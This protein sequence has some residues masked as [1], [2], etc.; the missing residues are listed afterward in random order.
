MMNWKRTND[1]VTS[2]KRKA[3]AKV[4]KFMKDRQHPPRTPP[5][6]VQSISESITPDTVNG[7]R[8]SSTLAERQ[9]MGRRVGQSNLLGSHAKGQA[10]ESLSSSISSGVRLELWAVGG[11]E[12]L[13]VGYGLKFLTGDWN[14]EL[15][16]LTWHGDDYALGGYGRRT[17]HADLPDDE[18]LRRETGK[19]LSVEDPVEGVRQGRRVVEEWR[20]SPN[21]GLIELLYPARLLDLVA[22]SMHSVSTRC[23]HE[24]YEP[25]QRE[26]VHEGLEIFDGGWGDLGRERWAAKAPT[27]DSLAQDPRDKY[28]FRYFFNIPAIT[29]TLLGQGRDDEIT[30]YPGKC[31]FGCV[32]HCLHPRTR[33]C[34][35]SCLVQEV[36]VHAGLF[37]WRACNRGSFSRRLAQ[38]RGWIHS[39]CVPWEDHSCSIWGKP[40]MVLISYDRVGVSGDRVGIKVLYVFSLGN[41]QFDRDRRLREVDGSAYY[42]LRDALFK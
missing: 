18:W 9:H 1:C 38:P 10:E 34:K 42:K 36:W 30:F 28:V 6:A 19:E 23:N 39:V 11:L 15:E 21:C 41:V 33:T 8:D 2:A 37:T 5:L 26:F 35:G 22:K 27:S 32:F 14:P 25:S 31:C 20:R 40:W 16:R 7:T 24:G 17:R 13:T 4:F 29:N 3:L 12:D